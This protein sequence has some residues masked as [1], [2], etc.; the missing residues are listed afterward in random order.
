MADV[1]RLLES[2]KLWQGTPKINQAI[3]V[4]NGLSKPAT[5]DRIADNAVNFEKMYVPEAQILNRNYIE[6]NYKT[7]KITILKNCSISIEKYAFNISPSQIELSLPDQSNDGVLHLLVY[8]HRTGELSCKPFTSAGDNELSIARLYGKKVYGQNYEFITFV[9]DDDNY[10]YLADR[11]ITVTNA[12]VAADALDYTRINMYEAT[13]IEKDKV[14][15]DLKRKK[16]IIKPN[17]FS[18]MGNDIFNLNQTGTNLYIDLPTDAKLYAFVLDITKSPFTVSFEVYND[19]TKFK[20]KRL[21]FYYYNNIPLGKNTNFIKVIGEMGEILT[22]KEIIHKHLNNPFVRT[23]IKLIGDSITAGLC[24]TGYS[25]T[26]KPI[27]NT[28][29]K[30]NVTTAVCWANMLRDHVISEYNREFDV[31]VNDPNISFLAATH[32]IVE[33]NATTFKWQAFFSNTTTNN[34]IQ[35][36]FYGDHF[37]IY[38]A[39]VGGGGIMDIYVDGVKW[40]ELD[41]YGTYADNVEKKITG[42]TLGDHLVEIRETN[43][44]NAGA[45][46]YSIYI[47]GLKIPKTADVV[48]FGISGKHS[49]YLYQQRDQLIES[50][51]S[52]VIMQIGTNDRHNFKTTA[53]TKSYQRELIKYIRSLGKDVI[54]MAANPVSVAND[55]EAVR[56]FKMDDVDRSIHQVTKEFK[57]DYIS[58]YKGYME[59]AVNTGVTIDSLLF[60]GLHPNDEGYKVMFENTAKGLGLTL[61]RDGVSYV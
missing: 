38:H 59:Y 37:S 28:G 56:N 22:I 41:T 27:G 11:K 47:Q 53:V 29:Y 30:T 31:S 13:I 18:T 48:N 1:P 49:Q 14:I 50:A 23:I 10:N 42:L 32:Q 55:M 39:T 61:L 9:S 3:D 34:G 26:D 51:D 40:G 36:T 33:N 12:N 20:N 21:L 15:V 52:I 4:I 2:D 60:D 46:G 25:A 24:G 44:K 43:R 54:V 58:N 17:T 57:M 6:V 7:R 35:F 16:A 8:N 45:S 5:R 19:K